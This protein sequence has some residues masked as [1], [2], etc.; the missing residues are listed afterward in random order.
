MA[1]TR[2]IEDRPSVLKTRA[3]YII[4]T[5]FCERL[6]YYGFAGSLVLF[7][8]TVLNY[9][10]ED[11]VNQ[12]YVW[13]GFVY[14]T[15]LIGGYVA[16]TYWS[17]YTTIKAFAIAYLFGLIGFNIGTI[18]GVDSAALVFMAIYIIALGA[19]GIK[20]NVSTLGADQFDVLNYEQDEKES[21]QFFSYFYWVINLGALLSY[22]V[23]GFCCQYGVPFLGGEDW[24]FFVG[25]AIAT[26]A[27]T[28]GI[29]AFMYGSDRYIIKEPE[30]SMLSTAIAIIL[31]ARKNA[32]LND[33]KGEDTNAHVSYQ[34]NQPAGRASTKESAQVAWEDHALPPSWLDNATRP[35][36][37]TGKAFSPAYVEC[38]KYVVR[39]VPFLTVMIP[40][41]GI[42]GQTKTAFQIQGCQMDLDLGGF[43]LPVSGMNI[44]NN[45]SIL[46]LVPLFESYLYPYLRAR[47]GGGEV[48]MLEKI[49]WGFVF[50]TV[51]M[52][53]A[54]LIELWRKQESPS[55]CTYLDS[56]C[57][58]NMTPCRNSD[59][60]DG[61]KYQEWYAGTE[62]DKPANCHQTCDVLD[63]DGNLSTSCISCDVMPQM[64]NLSVFWQAPQFIL[65]GISEIFASITSLEFFYSQAPSEMRSVSQASNLVT[66]AL[67]SWLTIPLTLLVNA[68]SKNKWIENNVDEGHLDLYF[69]LLA[70]LM[71]IT[72]VVF[73]HLAKSYTYVDQAV[74]ADVSNTCTREVQE[75]KKANESSGNTRSPLLT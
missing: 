35:D 10:N 17:R 9:S 32:A 21:K 4:A 22:T 45:I 64:S 53:V 43:N 71:A 54:A 24:G 65:I 23:I 74:L 62:D 27:M 33:G 56:G 1:E 46:I 25:M 60:Y 13:N 12:F 5:E 75:Q 34:S 51:A 8:E 31:L 70:A 29:A 30:G 55:D 20:P 36:E 61:Y 47:R 38:I 14:V 58:D 19:G 73:R 72:C 16:D 69:F 68:N 37:E 6:A 39:I 44:F 41:W 49:G 66:N 11:A 42:Y 7:F 52:V 48:E 40:F 15:P 57:K 28:L 59:D 2:G 26:I 18:P 67:G 63:D 50:A 3:I